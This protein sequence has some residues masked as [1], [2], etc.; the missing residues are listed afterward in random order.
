MSKIV[1]L[2]FEEV[3]VIPLE[4]IFIIAV[5]PGPSILAGN[6]GK[7]IAS[8]DADTY[9]WNSS[10]VKKIELIALYSESGRILPFDLFYLFKISRVY[11][12]SR[13]FKVILFSKELKVAIFR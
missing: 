10:P 7:S 12:E 2:I 6:I 4:A 8:R 1:E 13:F 9:K 3:F 11:V 5:I